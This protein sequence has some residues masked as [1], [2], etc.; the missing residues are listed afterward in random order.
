MSPAFPNWLTYLQ[1]LS[2]HEEKYRLIGVVHNHPSLVLTSH[3][4]QELL[5]IVAMMKLKLGLKTI[6]VSKAKYKLRGRKPGAGQNKIQDYQITYI[7]HF[8]HSKA[9]FFMNDRR[10]HIQIK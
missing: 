6:N 8:V 1:V 9:L 5:F 3:S 7:M 4:M 2:I 10:S